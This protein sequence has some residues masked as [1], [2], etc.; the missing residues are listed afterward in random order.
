MKRIIRALAGGLGLALALAGASLAADA[1]GDWLGTIAVG[2]GRTFHEAVHIEKTSQGGYAGTL[3]SLDRATFGIPL[4]DIAADADTLSF[5]VATQPVATYTAKWDSASGQWTGRWSQNGRTV[6]LILAKGV[7]A[8]RPTIGGLDGLW[9]GALAIGTTP[10]HLILHVRTGADG[11]AAWMDSP[12]QMANGLDVNSIQRDGASVR[13]AMTALNA[14]FAGALATDRQ[15]IAGQW[16]QGG[17]A[18][19]L[20]LTRRAPGFQPA[21]LLRP[22][23]PVKPYPYRE[24][25]VAFD[26]AAHVR[27]AGTL[28][29]PRGE[30]PFPAVVLVAGWGAHPRPEPGMGD[31]KFLVLADHLT[32]NGIAVLRYDKR[33]T[34][35]ST[36]DFASATTMD[37]AD[38]A[39]SGVAYLKSRKDIDLGHIGLIGHSEGGWIAPIVAVRDP[40]VAFIVMMAGP[41]VK[42]ADLQIEQSRLVYKAMGLSDAQLEKVAALS[43]N[44]AVIIR[45]EKDPA[46]AAA[47]LRA[48]MA[49]NAK[50]LGLPDNVADVQLSQMDS[51]WMRFALNYDPAPTLREVRCPV[52]A[53]DGSLD[54]QVPAEQNL[55]AIRAA[56]AG[57]P[58]AEVDELP[59]LNHAFQTAKTGAMG[60]YGEIEE[61]I[62][63]LALDTV[64]T[65]VLKHVGT[66]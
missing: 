53:I 4:S 54:R 6:P 15:N 12:D 20:T 33:G 42:G 50:A 41:G 61:T 23:T 47:K 21:A 62:A 48:A 63:P 8:S 19:P 3:D 29:L 46:V 24:E 44:A 1:S 22:Q 25:E 2:P 43:R 14:S 35:S 26:D 37:F 60:E 57:N 32:R 10:L 17:T 56:L 16:T 51:D 49:A 11:T 39:Q 9:D 18:T 27:L 28:T 5:T 34:G 31:Q 55:P 36:G 30:G 40:Q 59:G 7:A 64:T 38:D 66:H 45:A 58:D 13:F 65:W 52:L